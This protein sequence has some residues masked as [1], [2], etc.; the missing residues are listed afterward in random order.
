M[1]VIALNSSARI[2]GESKT[3]Y[4]QEHLLKGMQEAGAQVE[5]INLYQKKIKHCIGCFTCWTKTPGKCIHN[6]DMTSE[7][8]P[9]YLD[10]DIAVLATPLYKYS[11]SSIMK[12]FMDRALPALMPFFVEKDGVTSHP[13]RHE[14][15]EIVLLSVA[16][17]PEDSVFVPLHVL[18][19]KYYNNKLLAEIYRPGA[20]A[21]VRAAKA[22]KASSANDIME[23]TVQAGRELVEHRKISKKTMDRV[24]KPFGNLETLPPLVNAFWQSC[25]DEKV[26]PKQFEAKG[27][28]PRPPSIDV[29]I[30]IMK[31]GF[32]SKNAG[33]TNAVIAFEFSGKVT[34]DCY[35]TIK[36]GKCKSETG[37]AKKPDLTI[38]TPF[39]VWMDILTKK[40]DGAQMFTEEKY[41]VEGDITLLMKIKELF[42]R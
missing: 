37:K 17:F 19:T 9:K 3:E 29:F 2:G 21:M 20:E 25:I 40:V 22:G 12:T 33:D 11:V 5:V 30:K 38:M 15:P 26:T 42:G 10:A 16:G 8:L 31:M 24:L 23:A 18:A 14:I 39:E 1:K 36:D 28:V 34:G 32:N 6:D 4:M 41:K 7:I 13:Y 35:F 27:M